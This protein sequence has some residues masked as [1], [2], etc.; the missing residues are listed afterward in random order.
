MKECSVSFT[1]KLASVNNFP[2][3]YSMKTILQ[4]IAD[5]IIQR[6]GTISAIDTK[7]ADD[8]FAN[9]YKIGQELVYMSLTVFALE[10]D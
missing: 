7:K 4:F 1:N 10:L 6:M 9:L 5:K 3:I 8:E 2:Y